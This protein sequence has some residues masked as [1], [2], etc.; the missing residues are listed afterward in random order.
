MHS[1]FPDAKF[2]IMG[3][4]V[5]S[6]N[7][8][9]GSSYGATGDSYADGYGMVVT[10]L[11]MNKAY[12]DFANNKNYSE[13]VEFVNVSSQFDSEYC[14]PYAETPVNTR[15]AVTEIRGTNGVHPNS[16]GYMQIADVVYRN[17]VAN[18]CQ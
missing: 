4:Q 16:E 12:Q 1:E 6:I 14:M 8:G 13:F 15:C 10:A 9:I 11:N 3:L 7:G 2:K 17:F 18:F 5:P